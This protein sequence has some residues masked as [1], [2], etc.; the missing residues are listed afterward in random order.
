[1]IRITAIVLASGMSTRMKSDK[2]HLKLKDKYIYEYIL[3]TIKGYD[4]FETIV[5]AKDK[6]IL[7]KAEDLGYIGVDNPRYYLGQSKSIRAALRNSKDTDG[8]MFFVADQ[9]FIKLATIERL[10]SE[11]K[12]A[13]SKIILPYYNGIVGN[14]V[15]FP[16]YLKEELLGLEYDQ[17]GRV[18]IYRNLDIALG[19]DILTEYE[20][21]DIDTVEDY[22][23]AKKIVISNSHTE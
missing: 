16:S 20:H 21:I 19:V 8:F 1:M 6:D 7:K 12:R 9:P 22:E 17:G 13:P 4:F 2:L 23:K 18:V 15:I 14:P 11:F 5:V 3:E 10:C